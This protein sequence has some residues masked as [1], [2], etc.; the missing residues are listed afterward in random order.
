MAVNFSKNFH[1]IYNKKV[2]PEYV[3]QFEVNL[4][5]FLK[6][7]G[8]FSRYF[9][10]FCK[11]NLIR[12]FQ[13]NVS[14]KY[15]IF[16]IHKLVHKYCRKVMFFFCNINSFSQTWNYLLLYF[17]FDKCLNQEQ[18]EGEIRALWCSVRTVYVLETILIYSRYLATLFWFLKTDLNRRIIRRNI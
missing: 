15:V 11:Y 17:H 16:R 18:C 9:K 14:F 2:V 8:P 1:V 5:S 6:G 7:T 3:F 10:C 12:R 4:K 13:I